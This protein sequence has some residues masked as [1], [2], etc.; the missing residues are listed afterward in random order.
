MM[1][2][3]DR[4]TFSPAAKRLA[5]LARLPGAGLCYVV[6]MTPFLHMGS[7]SEYSP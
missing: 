3:F 2:V 6:S 7:Y 1:R 5:A 4:I